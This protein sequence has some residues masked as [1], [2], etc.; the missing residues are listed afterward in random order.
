MEAN[1]LLA[2][3]LPSLANELKELLEK[4]GESTLAI[5]I[6][7][8][9]IVDRCGDGFCATFDVQPKP[10]GAYGKNHRPLEP[11]RGMLVLDVVG[12]AIACIEVLYR[13]DIRKTIELALP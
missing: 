13:D 11:R 2:S 12:G 3:L 10:S 1:P 4:P 6:P 9:R 7:S 8:L 5:Q